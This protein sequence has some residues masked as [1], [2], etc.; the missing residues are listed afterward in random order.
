[1]LENFP[2]SA[3]VIKQW[4]LEILLDSIN[5]SEVP[6]DFK[7]F[8]RQQGLDNERVEGILN[9]S[10]HL[11]FDVFDSFKIYIQI[12][13]GEIPNLFW[14]RIGDV[15]STIGYEKRINAEKAAIEEAFKQLEIKL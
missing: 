4:L 9:N 15:I 5:N 3:V 8:A 1:M 7:E 13:I 2:K 12:E 11:L 6:E 10:P 14:W